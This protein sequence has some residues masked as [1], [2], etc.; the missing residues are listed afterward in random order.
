MSATDQLGP[1]HLGARCLVTGGAGYV[2]RNLIRRLGKQGCAVTSFDVI[3]HSHGDGVATV[4]GDLRDYGAVRAACEGV[5]TVFHTAALINTLSLYR[6]AE[7]RFVFEVNA[8]GTGNV[9]RAAG[10]A[11]VGAVVHTSS[12]NVAL[13]GSAAAQ[14]ESLPYAVGAR[15]LYTLSKIEAEKAALAAD[16]PG[17]LRVCALRPG[18]IWGTDTGSMMIR[19]FLEQLAAGKFKALVGDKNT[20]TDNTH[21]DNLVDA[22]LLAARALRAA[23]EAVGG[24]AFY[25]T[26]GEP[27]NGMAWF[28]PLVEGVGFRFPTTWLPMWLIR[29]VARVAE[30]SHY[31][32]APMPMLTVRGVNNLAENS[33]LSIAKAQRLLGY[34]PRYT[35]ATAVPLLLPAA[36]DFIAARQG[37]KA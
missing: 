26:D 28:R 19:S 23:P 29:T 15:D 21:V 10:E 11:G 4:V 35:S 37:R 7:R 22:M 17:S 8:G 18:G 34:T 9:V 36:R 1:A 24:Q 33:R 32:G 14:D 31:L 2:G 30:L 13:D 16:R 3:A 12:F 20:V 25:I 27:M 5:D 6:Q